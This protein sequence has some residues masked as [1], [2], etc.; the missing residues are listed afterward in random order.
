MVIHENIRKI[1]MMD[2]LI[3]QTC[4]AHL[5]WNKIASDIKF[6]FYSLAIRKE[7][8]GDTSDGFII[9]DDK[10]DSWRR[11]HNQDL[12]YL[13]SSPNI[14]RVIKLRK[15]R[16]AGYVMR[17]G[18]KSGVRRLLVGK[19][20]WRRPLGR[21]RRKWIDNNRRDLQ[22]VGYMD[23]I[24]LAQDRDRWQTHVSAVMNLWVPWNA[25]NL[26]TSCRLVSFSRRTLL[27]GVR[28]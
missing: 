1:L 16:W 20:G 6:V 24:G 21:P 4:W 14:L 12:N 15:M 17:I 2:I 25:R 9:I 22:E 11:L 10:G 26:L 28:K 7:I 8:S 3:S 13:Y 18:D 19:P 23:W 27:H 5:K